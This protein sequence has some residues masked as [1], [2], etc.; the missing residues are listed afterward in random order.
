MGIEENKRLVRRLVQE[1]VNE[2]NID[3]LNEIAEGDKV[4]AT[5]SARARTRA[6]GTASQPPGG[7]STTWMRSTSSA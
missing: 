7:A 6:T 3:A 1:V 2:R 5:S 4:V